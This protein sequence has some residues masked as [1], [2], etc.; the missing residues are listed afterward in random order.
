MFK[1]II[2]GCHRVSQGVTVAAVINS[3]SGSNDAAP[4][5]LIL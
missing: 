2:T 3:L 1:H 4:S 5:V